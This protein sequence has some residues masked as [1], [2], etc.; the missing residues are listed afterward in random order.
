[1]SS[2]ARRDDTEH[3]MMRPAEEYRQQMPS[4]YE[5]VPT[6][7][8]RIACAEGQTGRLTEVQLPPGPARTSLHP[9]LLACHHSVVR[10]SGFG[11]FQN[12]KYLWLVCW[13]F[14]FT[15]T[16]DSQ[17]NR[18][19]RTKV[20]CH[21]GRPQPHR[22]GRPLALQ[23]F[24]TE[25]EAKECQPCVVYGGVSDERFRVAP[26]FSAVKRAVPRNSLG[27]EV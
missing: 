8:K 7:L 10:R 15:D 16:L 18:M 27:T 1:M 3:L 6:G 14:R 21:L 12:F 17:A 13:F 4:E 20:C 19:T 25:C 24:R 26:R 22:L 9:R 11:E 2:P 23:V 5:A